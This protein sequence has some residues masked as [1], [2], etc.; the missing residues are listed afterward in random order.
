MKLKNVSNQT[1]VIADAGRLVAVEAGGDV[2]VSFEAA[3]RLLLQPELWVPVL[4]APGYEVRA[5]G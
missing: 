4:D 2:A 5:A 1:L 3:L